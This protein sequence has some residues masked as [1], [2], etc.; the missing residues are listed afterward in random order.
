[1][2]QIFFGS[3]IKGTE[4]SLLK[5]DINTIPGIFRISIL[6]LSSNAEKICKKRILSTLFSQNIQLNQ[7]HYIINISTQGITPI[8]YAYD[9]PI[10]SSILM[11]IKKLSEKESNFLNESVLM[12]EL[13][14]DGSIMAVR[15]SISVALKLRQFK[16]IKRLI[17]PIQNLKE[18]SILKGYPIFGIEHVSQLSTIDNLLPLPPH[19]KTL[20]NKTYYDF[21]QIYGHSQA[22]RA[23]EISAA[24]FHHL[25][26][27][28]PPGSGKT[29]IAKRMPSIMNKL[30][31]DEQIECTEIY[32]IAN[33]LDENSIITDRPFRSPH[34]SST[35]V[36]II[37]GGKPPYPGEI[38]LSHRGILFI[39][40]FLQVRK[41]TIESLRQILEERSV[42]IKKYNYMVEFPASFLLIAAF[43]L[44]PCGY[45]ISPNKNC[46]CSLAQ[47]KNYISKVSGPI[48]ERF[49][50][51]VFVPSI[52]LDTIDYS[53]EQESS[54][55]IK[56]RVSD[57]ISIQKNRNKNGV[58]NG[59]LNGYEIEKNLCLASDCQTFIKKVMSKLSISMRSYHKILK[60]SQTIA[61][62]EGESLVKVSHI[63]E[64]LSF[65]SFEKFVEDLNGN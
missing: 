59:L 36:G 2:S 27:F 40:E 34:Y 47:I 58:F 9:L 61:D 63:K 48:L 62:L 41:S 65:R 29:M 17:I 25:M 18:C 15:G 14:L 52:P 13:S 28:G 54:E 20:S 37:G 42:S 32:S 4:V 46:T 33:L 12:G 49:D 45:Y 3:L 7:C 5:V 30:N 64:A 22:K 10:I 6:G 8:D 53:L 26:L 21:H 56:K 51:Q 55:T 43:N 44:C 16:N 57:A 31:I 23:A 50:L 24:G 60:I 38:S 11:Y 39:D 35:E 19:E 1:M